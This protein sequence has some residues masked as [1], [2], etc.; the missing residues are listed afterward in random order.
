MVPWSGKREKAVPFI[1]MNGQDIRDLK[2][3]WEKAAD[4]LSLP[5]D[6]GFVGRA[7]SDAEGGWHTVD[8]GEGSSRDW[9]VEV[10]P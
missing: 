1:G 8:T 9:G 4:A 2:T 6:W 5:K 10:G 3:S 7:S